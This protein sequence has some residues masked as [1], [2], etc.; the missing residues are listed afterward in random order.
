MIQHL[1]T[2]ALPAPV[3]MIAVAGPR[4]RVDQLDALTA[5]SP[6]ARSSLNSD[7]HLYNWP[8]PLI[9]ARLGQKYKSQGL[10]V[11]GVH[12]PEFGFEKDVDNAR[13]P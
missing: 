2:A 11:I 6:R 13:R 10:V 1:L 12:S 5:A 3:R 9:H 4:R 7:V 8:D